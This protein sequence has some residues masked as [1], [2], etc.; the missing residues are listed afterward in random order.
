MTLLLVYKKSHAMQQKLFKT[1]LLAAL[2]VAA[3]VWALSYPLSGLA[4]F[5][6]AMV[7]TF[8]GIKIYDINSSKTG[9]VNDEP[10]PDQKRLPKVPASSGRSMP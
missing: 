9:G 8:S 3:L 1:I 7:A 2:A 10:S 4:W 6:G 5:P